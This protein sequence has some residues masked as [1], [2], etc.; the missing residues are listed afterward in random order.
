MRH[1]IQNL[2][3]QCFLFLMLFFST[4]ANAQTPEILYYKFNGEGI[5][6]PNLATNPPAGTENAFIQGSQSQG[7]IGQSGGALV[8][9][10]GSSTNNYVN[11]QWAPNLGNSSWTIAFWSNNITNSPELYYIFGDVSTTSLRCFT[12]GVAGQG[13][14]MLRGPVPDII[15]SGG[16]ANGPNITAFVYDNIAGNIKAY[17]NGVLV[18]TVTAGPLNLTGPG[19]FKVG[20]YSTNNALNSGGLLD[21]FRFYNRPLNETEIIGLSSIEPE[22]S[23]V[24]SLNPFEACTNTASASQ[25]LMVSGT[26]LENSVILTAPENFEVSFNA[27]NDFG[28]SLNISPINGSLAQTPVYVRLSANANGNYSGSLNLSSDGVSTVELGLSGITSACSLPVANCYSN[29]ITL[30]VNPSHLV[31][32][33]AGAADVYSVNASLLDNGSTSTTTAV[34]EVARLSFP[35]SA[36]SSATST[37]NWT[38]NGICTDANPGG[39]ITDEDKGYSW[40]SCLAITPADFNKIRNYKLKISNGAGPSICTNGKYKIIY[41]SGGTAPEFSIIETPSFDFED[42]GQMITAYPNP[43]GNNLYID[44]NLDYK[45]LSNYS[46]A[47]I[48]A[49]GREVKTFSRLDSSFYNIDASNFA[50][51]L[52]SILVKSGDSMY[53]AKWI[54]I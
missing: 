12:S 51:G 9:S 53:T 21:E 29:T 37:F 6:V 16:A 54:K 3:L 26:D 39:G 45:K 42:G 49:M 10:G 19:P 30:T 31:Y 13:N 8:G 11:T 44:I 41:S 34:R 48:D 40:E 18:N 35:V 1:F 43:G 32:N 28:S 15:A 50:E 23:L 4:I 7:G 17:V 22:L 14:W 5:I 20:G 24:G 27:V 25:S 47:I 46:M 38:T 52:Y 36:S 33:G 2:Q